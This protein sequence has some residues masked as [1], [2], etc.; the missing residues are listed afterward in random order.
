[1]DDNTPYITTVEIFDVW[2]VN[3]VEWDTRSDG[4]QVTISKQMSSKGAA[5]IEAQ[6]WAK[7]EGLE[8]R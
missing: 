2:H 6:E 8:V 4:Y 1:M 5:W 3:L 7:R